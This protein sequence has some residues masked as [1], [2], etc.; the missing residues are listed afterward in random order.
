MN[1]KIWVWQIVTVYM[2]MDCKC[3]SD[4]YMAQHVTLLQFTQISY[5]SVVFKE[6][7]KYKTV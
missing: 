4:P 1:D 2:D 5:N 6:A 3:F 7:L